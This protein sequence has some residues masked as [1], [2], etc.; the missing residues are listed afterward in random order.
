MRALALILAL[1]FAGSSAGYSYLLYHCARGGSS[2]ERCCC[3]RKVACA[4]DG[5][6]DRVARAR[7]C[8]VEKVE[9]SLASVA[10]EKGSGDQTRL[11][12]LPQAL[13]GLIALPSFTAHTQREEKAV[14]TT[15]PP[16][17][18]RKCVLLA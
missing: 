5:Q 10:L 3:K 15:G 18:L 7:C 2:T 1:T 12:R 17:L 6:L 8:A 16:I 4:Q 11:A 14:A 13:F 9:L